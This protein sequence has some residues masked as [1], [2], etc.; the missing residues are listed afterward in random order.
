MITKPKRR[1][2]KKKSKAL[3]VTRRRPSAA[4]RRR[5]EE[6]LRVANAEL[7]ARNVALE[8]EAEERRRRIRAEFVRTLIDRGAENRHALL[9]SR[10]RLWRAAGGKETAGAGADPDTWLGRSYTSGRRR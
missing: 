7:E 6:A 10:R 9:P 2:K 5:Q 1:S 4:V 3:V 8:R